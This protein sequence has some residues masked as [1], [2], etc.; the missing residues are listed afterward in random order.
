MSS[1]ATQADLL[2]IVSDLR[3]MAAAEP[4]AKVREAL[5]RLVDRYTR[6]SSGSGLAAPVMKPAVRAR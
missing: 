1:I 2:E 3:V 4:T 5:N 6:M